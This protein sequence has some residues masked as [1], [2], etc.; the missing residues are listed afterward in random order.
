MGIY[1]SRT[2]PFSS[3]VFTPICLDVSLV[4]YPSSSV[5]L[6][7]QENRRRAKEEITNMEKEMAL[8]EDQLRARREKQEKSNTGSAKW[9]GNHFSSSWLLFIHRPHPT[10]VP[11]GPHFPYTV[12]IETFNLPASL[13]IHIFTRPSSSFSCSLYPTSL[14]LHD[15]LFSPLVPPDETKRN[16]IDSW[17][18][19]ITAAI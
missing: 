9:V 2:L 3:A 5:W 1:Y 16:N 7:L 10:I 11:Y 15:E 6:S 14:T 13:T 17:L 19:P 12:K 18:T 4:E 8:A